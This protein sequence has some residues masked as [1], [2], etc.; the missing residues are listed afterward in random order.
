MHVHHGAAPA[1]R[2]CRGS[3]G[4]TDE[5]TRSPRARAPPP[6]RSPTSSVALVRDFG[7]R[8]ITNATR[9]ASSTATAKASPMPRCRTSSSIPHTNEEVAAIVRLCH[10][11]RVPVIAF[12]VGTSLEGH[13]AALYGGVCVD[14]SRDEPRARGQRRR[15]RLPRAGGRHARAAQR[16]AQGHRPVLPDRSGRERDARRH[17]VDARVRHQRRALRHDARERARPDGRHRRT[18]A[19]CAP[20]VARASRAPAT[21]SRACS[22]AP[23]G[24]LGIITEIQLRLYGVPEAISAAVCQF[25]DLERGGATR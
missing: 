25:P 9:S 21:T 3:E 20:A 14:L 22:S 4:P 1:S 7:E 8:A 2:S 11:A 12:G 23:E 16:R 18:A 10:A 24:T 19:S 15:P 6:R 5:R 17:G 13:V